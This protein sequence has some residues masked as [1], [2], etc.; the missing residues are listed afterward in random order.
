MNV[1][2][3]ADNDFRKLENAGSFAAIL[4]KN[5][6]KWTE[7]GYTRLSDCYVF[8]TSGTPAGGICF[9]DDSAEELE[10]LDFAVNNIASGDYAY[11]T[12][13]ISLAARPE[14]KK[15]AYN[16]YN[17]TEQYKDLISLFVEAGF[18][19]QQ[20][21][22]AFTY[23]KSAE[24]IFD[25]ILHFKNIDQVGEETFTS[26]VEEVTRNTLDSLMGDDANRLGADRAASEFVS[27]L[28]HID[29]TPEWWQLGYINNE[30]VGLILSQRFDDKEGAIN[31]IG[32]LPK[33]RGK[34]YGL[35]LIAEGTR[36]L[37]KSGITK[38]YADID[39]ANTP[40]KAALEKLGF[41]FKME[42]V[43]LTKVV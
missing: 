34:G 3:I 6:K 30:P 33:L 40:M 19:V 23:E 8:E 12:K 2:N 20:E 11:L 13:A 42:Q 4:G 28:K 1:R 5:I 36:V 37:L 17:D 43:V 14:T 32:V 29:F 39:A 21:K 26:M 18:F 7:K 27:S 41:N 16:L 25:N 9:C 35:H 15:I 10:I 38:I 31:Y 22:R 24:F